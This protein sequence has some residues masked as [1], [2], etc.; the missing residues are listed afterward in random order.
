MRIT[1]NLLK[2]GNEVG[3]ERQKGEKRESMENHSGRHR[4]GMCT[5][6]SRGSKPRTDSTRV[7]LGA[8]RLLQTRT[9][10]SR[11]S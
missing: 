11:D 4:E 2:N 8:E 9:C 6:V 1:K 5:H 10:V 7:C 3:E